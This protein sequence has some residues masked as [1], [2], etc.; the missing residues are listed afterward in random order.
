MV[1]GNTLSGKKTVSKKKTNKIIREKDKI[2][3]E[4][5]KIIREKDKIIREK[6][7]NL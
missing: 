3:R 5:D 2:I 1:L 4:K 6:R 7:Q